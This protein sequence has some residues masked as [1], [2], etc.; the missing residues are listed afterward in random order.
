MPNTSH[1]FSLFPCI[2]SYRNRHLGQHIVEFEDSLTKFGR[3]NPS[4][5]VQK[6]SVLHKVDSSNLHNIYPVKEI[7][8][9]KI[10]YFN[11]EHMSLFYSTDLIVLKNI[12]KRKTWRKDKQSCYLSALYK[13]SVCF[14]VEFFGLPH[15]GGHNI[16]NQS[17][18]LTM[19]VYINI[20]TLAIFKEAHGSAIIGNFY[21]QKSAKFYWVGEVL[22]Y[23]RN[24]WPRGRWCI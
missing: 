4:I 19:N 22:A 6:R 11:K 9:L 13:K 16:W 2:E 21:K 24:F 20:S 7:S 10:I 23:F 18:T 12:I 14:G 1:Q 5:R 17:L 8:L 3:A 15:P